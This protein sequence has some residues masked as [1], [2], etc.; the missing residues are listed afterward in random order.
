M[1][2]IDKMILLQ[3]KYVLLY[4]FNKS[5]MIKPSFN[6]QMYRHDNLMLCRVIRY[7]I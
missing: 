3:D 2:S 4:D 1:V 5:E 6:L 7:V